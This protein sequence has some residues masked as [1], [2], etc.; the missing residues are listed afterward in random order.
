MKS[1]QTG[2]QQQNDKFKSPNTWK[3]KTYFSIFYGMTSLKSN[4]NICNNENEKYQSLQSTMRTLCREKIIAL[5]S[6]VRNFKK[7]QIK[8]SSSKNKIK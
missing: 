6:Y 4:K 2:N 8:P 5:N 7:S 1:N 3:V